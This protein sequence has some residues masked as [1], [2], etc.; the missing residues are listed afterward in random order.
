MAGKGLSRVSSSILLRPSFVPQ[1]LVEYR[2]EPFICISLPPLFEIYLCPNPL[3]SLVTH[4]FWFLSGKVRVSRKPV[5]PFVPNPVKNF[6]TSV[7]SPNIGYSKPVPKPVL[8]SWF[9]M[10][11]IVSCLFFHVFVITVRTRENTALCAHTQ[12]ENMCS[13]AVF[14]VFSFRKVSRFWKPR[15]C[16]SILGY[17]S[18][19]NNIFSSLGSLGPRYIFVYLELFI[20]IYPLAI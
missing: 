9:C 2:T 3:H 15:V 18:K 8:S 13:T 19:K 4:L 12:G 5:F 16:F 11:G 17:F 6:C 10:S 7:L 20:I 14:K 1:L